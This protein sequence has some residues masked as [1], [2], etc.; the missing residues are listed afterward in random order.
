[1][2]HLDVGVVVDVAVQHGHRVRALALGAR[3]LGLLAVDRVAV[4]L[5]DD[6]DAGPAGVAEHRHARLGLGEREPQQVVGV[7]RGAQ[8][9]TLSPSSPISA[10]AL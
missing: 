7:H 2:V 3:H 8:R 10:A 1:M 6:A 9:R 5:A 4:G